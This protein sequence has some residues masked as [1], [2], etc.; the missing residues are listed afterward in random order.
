MAAVTCVRSLECGIVTQWDAWP[1]QIWGVL[2]AQ[3]LW[4]DFGMLR[5]VS[6]EP[7]RKTRHDAL[8]LSYH[9]PLQHSWNF[10]AHFMVRKNRYQTGFVKNANNKLLKKKLYFMNNFKTLFLMI[11][12][13]TILQYLFRTVIIK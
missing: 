13:G 11:H 4:P 6:T 3:K 10:K 2:D 5:C 1:L 8:L 7:V 12:T 9:A